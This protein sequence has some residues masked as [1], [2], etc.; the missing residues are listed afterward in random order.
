MTLSFPRTGIIDQFHVE[1]TDFELK[2]RQEFSRTAGGKTYGK[3]LGPALWRASYTSAEMPISQAV[4][5][6]A[7]LHSLDGVVRTLY[8][9]DVRRPY[10][11]RRPLGDF[12][13]DAQIYAISANGR[14]RLENLPAGMVLSV[15]DYFAFNYAGGRALHQ[16]MEQVTT[17]G[18]GIT[19]YFEVRPYLRPG[20][21]VG[22]AV[23]L[24]KPGCIA[25]LE[26]DSIS[27]RPRSPMTATVSFS[28]WQDLD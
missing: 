1:D 5:V 18:L 17:D 9:Y 2:A 25:R 11:L 23:I 20:V 13:D 12:T 4:T 26:P 15:G 7:T 22:V 19:P 10:P 8:I 21:A 14:V 27:V 3:D 24:K 28:A 6:Q 16:V